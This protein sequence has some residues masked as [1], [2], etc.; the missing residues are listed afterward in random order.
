[1]LNK[2]EL[3]KLEKEEIIA[4]MLGIIEQLSAEVAEL[5]ARLGMNSQNSS[6]PPSSDGYKKPKPVSLRKASGNPVGGV[7]KKVEGNK[8]IDKAGNQ[9]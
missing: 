7:A 9:G 3:M 1:M 2:D 5:K 6:K 4:L 8:T